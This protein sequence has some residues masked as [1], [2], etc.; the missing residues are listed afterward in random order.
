MCVE[1]IAYT[2]GWGEN[3]IFRDLFLSSKQDYKALQTG[4]YF[5]L[6]FF[7]FNEQIKSSIHKLLVQ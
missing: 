4:A 6:F 7:F 5:F 1:E 2:A 3:V